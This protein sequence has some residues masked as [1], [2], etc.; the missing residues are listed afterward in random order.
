MRGSFCYLNS[1]V[2]RRSVSSVQ[3]TQRLSRSRRHLSVSPRVRMS[4]RTIYSACHVNFLAFEYL[5]TLLAAPCLHFGLS[6]PTHSPSVHLSPVLRIII[7]CLKMLKLIHA[8]RFVASHLTCPDGMHR[9]V[10]LRLPY[11]EKSSVSPLTAVCGH[12]TW[13]LPSGEKQ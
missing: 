1:F 13:S 3:E 10:L 9:R 6:S 8:K 5:V 4:Y 7:R 2:P 11:A 12:R